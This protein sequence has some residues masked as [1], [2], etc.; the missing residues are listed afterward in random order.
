[1][2]SW[3]QRVFQRHNKWLFGFLLT[4]IIVAFVLTITPAGGGLSGRAETQFRKR[5]FFGTNLASQREVQD[6]MLAAQVS[7]WISTGTRRFRQ[8]QI[9]PLALQRTAYL[10]LADQLSIPGPSMK[11]RE[12]LIRSKRIFAGPDGQFAPDVYRKFLDSLKTDGSFSEEKVLRALIEDYRIDA[13][14]QALVGPGFVQEWEAI[15]RV[16]DLETVWSVNLGSLSYR[17]FAPEIGMDD[18]VIAAYFAD[19]EEEYREHEKARATVLK[20]S[21]PQ[22][23]DKVVSNPTEEDLQVYFEINWNRFTRPSVEGEEEET[24]TPV[25]L[26]D[27]RDEVVRSWISDEAKKIAQTAAVTFVSALYDRKIAAD[28]DEFRSLVAESHVSSTV[29]EPFSRDVAASQEGLLPSHLKRVFDLPPNR[30]YTDEPV[31]TPDGAAILIFYGT[32][33]PRIPALD[34]IRNV[35]EANYRESERRALFDRRGVELRALFEA[36][37]ADGEAFAEVAQT[38]GLTVTDLDEFTSRE[39]P[40]EFDRALFAQ[41][42]RLQPGQISPMVFLNGEGKFVY[43]K[44]KEVPQIAADSEEVEETLSQISYFSSVFA[45][46]TIISEIVSDELLKADSTSP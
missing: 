37:I 45:G 16:E 33:A 8:N 23:I 43:L 18:D 40:S 10:F 19:H 20:F 21:A 5:D 13:V 38:E 3:I 12:A 14:R 46:Q 9:E 15:K 34:E 27:V 22:Y 29:L 26:D 25:S 4:V 24:D 42:T 30:Y 32:I 2:I 11:Q 44:S 41:N 1:M 28:S 31:Q 6:V 39:P 7:T 17:D 35:V 36:A